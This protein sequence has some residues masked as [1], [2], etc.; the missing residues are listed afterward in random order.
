MWDEEFRKS[1]SELWPR[2]KIFRKCVRGCRRDSAKNK[3]TVKNKATKPK[4][5]SLKDLSRGNSE[6]KSNKKKG[7]V[8]EKLSEGLPG[9]IF[10]CNES[11]MI[12]IRLQKFYFV[13][14]LRLRFQLP[15]HRNFFQQTHNNFH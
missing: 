1:L 7:E 4:K 9:F 12:L 2:H 11:K 14:T 6:D 3:S 5:I 10:Y 13:A 15:S 8:K